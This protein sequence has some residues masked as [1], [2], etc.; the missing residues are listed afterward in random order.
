[1]TCTVLYS[2]IYIYAYNTIGRYT[3]IIYNRYE[4]DLLFF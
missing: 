2:D 4:N 1:M 3:F